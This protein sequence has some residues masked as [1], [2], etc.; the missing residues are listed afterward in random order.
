M[1]RKVSSV[2]AASSTAYKTT[3]KRLSASDAASAANQGKAI[4]QLIRFDPEKNGT[5]IESYEYDKH[6]D[7]MVLDLLTAVKAHQDPSLA[8]R[9]SCCEGV[10][11]SCAMNINGINSLACI[12]FAQQVT[13]VGPLPN[14][15]VIKDF[16]VDL[17]YFFQQYSFIRPFVRNTLLHRSRIDG[18]IDRYQALSKSLYHVSPSK[19]KGQLQ[20]ETETLAMSA[21]EKK[22]KTAVPVTSALVQ[23]LDVAMKA[24]SVEHAV[25]ILEAL[26]KR[27]VELSAESIAKYLKSSSGSLSRA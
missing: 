24:E 7:Y 20:L 21:A 11:G 12:T 13:T 19:A 4:L 22:R 2:A 15:P 10:C 27:G 14:F 3:V 26:E 8:F 17:R 25:M 5:R 1:L 16:V 6:H 9:S 18:V 23:L